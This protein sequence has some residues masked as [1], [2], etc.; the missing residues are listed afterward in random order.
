M[1]YLYDPAATVTPSL[2]FRTGITVNT[3]RVV[4]ILLVLPVALEW[5]YKSVALTS[6]ARSQLL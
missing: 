5:F 4:I 6:A 2:T 1:D 3:Q